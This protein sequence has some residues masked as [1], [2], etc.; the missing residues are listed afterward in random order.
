MKPFAGFDETIR[1]RVSFDIG[2][3]ITS[4]GNGTET[5]NLIVTRG[6]AL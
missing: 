6:A 3:P 4:D 1:F 2:F 5:V